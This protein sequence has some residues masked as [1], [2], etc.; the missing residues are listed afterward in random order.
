M[1]NSI[2]TSA[3]QLGVAL[4]GLATAASAMAAPVPEASPPALTTGFKVDWVSVDLTKIPHSLADADNVLAGTGGFVVTG[5]TT[6]Y[7]NTIDFSDATV[8]FT[9]SDGDP[10]FAVHA[11]G[12]VTLAA[13]SYQF[14]AYHDDGARL[15]V[16]GETVINFPTDTGPTTTWSAVYTLPAGV[17]S[18][19][20]VGW[21]QGGQFVF[22]LGTAQTVNSTSIDLLNGFHAAAVPEP[23]AAA[24]LAAGLALVGWVGARRRRHIG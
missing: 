8:P 6:Q 16:G 14:A 17:Y 9:A 11:Y 18:F 12:F 1:R 4:A 2:K 24:M 21:E 10:R 5:S 20:A 13:G 22:K 7:L 19:D 3:G 15:I 23:G